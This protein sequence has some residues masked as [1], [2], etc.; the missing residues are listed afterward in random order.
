MKNILC[1]KCA[2]L[3]LSYEERRRV[4]LL[5]REG[6][7]VCGHC[8]FEIIKKGHMVYGNRTMRGARV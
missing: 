2:M 6:V 7:N 3:L 5:L 8:G 1:G 4:H